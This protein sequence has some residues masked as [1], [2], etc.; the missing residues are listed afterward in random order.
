MPPYF[1]TPFQ[2]SYSIAKTLVGLEHGGILVR[3][4]SIHLVWISDASSAASEA[5]LVSFDSVA[6]P[7]PEGGAYCA[8]RVAS[9]SAQGE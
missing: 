8:A 4:L 2:A 1:D 9:I 5:K 7:T 3:D 6:L